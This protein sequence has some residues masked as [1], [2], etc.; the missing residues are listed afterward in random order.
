MG[1]TYCSDLACREPQLTTPD[2]RILKVL[3]VE[4]QPPL[5]RDPTGA[6]NG[7]KPTSVYDLLYEEHTGGK[8]PRGKHAV[9]ARAD[10]APRDYS[11][12][13]PATAVLLTA[14]QIHEEYATKG[15]RGRKPTVGLKT[16]ASVKTA[17]YGGKATLTNMPGL[18]DVSEAQAGLIV[19]GKRYWYA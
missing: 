19:R 15:G 7:G 4:G 10:D 16:A 5:V 12:F 9:P 8:L 11:T 18:F 14:S 3:L 17:Y 13:D 1:Y 6:I 2:G